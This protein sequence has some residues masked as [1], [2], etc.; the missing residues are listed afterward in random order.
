[1]VKEKTHT[2]LPKIYFEICIKRN[3][4]TNK[5][6]TIAIIQQTKKQFRNFFFT[7]ILFVFFLFFY[8]FHN[9]IKVYMKYRP[10]EMR[11]K[12]KRKS[13]QQHIEFEWCSN[14]PSKSKQNINCKKRETKKYKNDSRDNVATWNIHMD[15]RQ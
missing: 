8:S 7:T 12:L 14:A 11:K 9:E 15:V 4:C 5:L 3:V 2:S 10:K 6:Q 13:C 1:M